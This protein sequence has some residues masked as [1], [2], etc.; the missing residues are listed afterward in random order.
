MHKPFSKQALKKTT[1]SEQ[2]YNQHSMNTAKQE[3]I[4]VLAFN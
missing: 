1:E 3:Q 2:I 4:L